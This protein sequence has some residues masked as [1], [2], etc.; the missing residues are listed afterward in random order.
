MI[1]TKLKQGS[2]YS[3]L[4][5][6]L[7]LL[8]CM[9]AL[10]WA[11]NLQLAK[12]AEQ[13][14]GQTLIY[15]PSYQR[16]VY[17]MGDIPLLRGVCSDVLIRALRTSQQIDLQQL[18]HKDMARHFSAYP[19]TWGLTKPDKNIDH[20]RVPNIEVFLTRQGKSIAV[21]QQPQDYHTGDIV[22]WR[23]DN[24]RPHIGIV[25]TYTNELGIPLIIHNIG[26]GVR[27]EDVLFAWP[28]IG[29]YRYFED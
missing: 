3:Y 24:G 25:S 6:L 15:D 9:P 17:P 1:G 26:W 8:I 18:I 14:I 12:A 7:L 23:L 21:T 28:I 20:R 16:L 4:K 27:K 29:H 10:A 22:S 19:N 13:Q 11:G 2:Y 5:K